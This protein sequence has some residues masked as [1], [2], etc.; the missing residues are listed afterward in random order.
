MTNQTQTATLPAHDDVVSLTGVEY[1]V[2]RTDTVEVGAA[3]GGDV[4]FT[5][6]HG[7]A[8]RSPEEAQAIPLALAAAHNYAK[9]QQ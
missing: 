5:D 2:W 8:A 7:Q 9:E 6:R 1:R 4:L 3:L